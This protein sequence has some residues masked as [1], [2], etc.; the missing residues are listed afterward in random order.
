MAEPDPN[1]QPKLKLKPGV[2]MEDLDVETE[3]IKVPSK[4]MIIPKGLVKPLPTL[5]KAENNASSKF[6]ATPQTI[7]RDNIVRSS[8]MS[9]KKIADNF[10]APIAV[11]K[12]TQQ[13]MAYFKAN[14]EV[15]KGRGAIASAM[16]ESEEDYSDDN[17]DDNFDEPDDEE[18]A[19]FEKMRRQM[20]RENTKANKAVEQ[21]RI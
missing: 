16:P 15:A 13:D 11:V 8:Q 10:V 3:T 21:G 20:A 7:K 12:K 4:P 6:L 9:E 5:K 1:E 19:K 14:P 2:D 18:D 17:Y